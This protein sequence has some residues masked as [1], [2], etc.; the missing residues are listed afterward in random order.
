MAMLCVA[1]GLRPGDIFLVDNEEF[2]VVKT[3]TSNGP[4]VTRHNKKDSEYSLDKN[5]QVMVTGSIYP[6]RDAEIKKAN[7]EGRSAVSKKK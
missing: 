5:V 1:Y 2:I 3:R 6:S 7:A 4:I